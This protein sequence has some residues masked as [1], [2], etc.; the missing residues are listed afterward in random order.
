MELLARDPRFAN[1]GRHGVNKYDNDLNSDYDHND[2]GVRRRRQ[3]PR[4]LRTAL[5]GNPP[6]TINPV[7]T[8]GTFSPTATAQWAGYYTTRRAR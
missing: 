8:G 7:T 5:P 2:I 1:K 3:S 4:R 6:V